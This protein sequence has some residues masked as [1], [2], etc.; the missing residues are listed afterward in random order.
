MAST[1][2]T[3]QD[4]EELVAAVKS[5]TQD[6]T[7]KH[8]QNEAWARS[9]MPVENDLG[10]DLRMFATANLKEPSLF[11]FSLVV[12]RAFRIRGLCVNRGH[13][14]KHTDRN[15]WRPGTH[16]HRW[17]DKCRDRFAYTPTIEISTNIPAAFDEFC[18][19]CNIEFT[20]QVRPLPSRQMD[21]SEAAQA[22]S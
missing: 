3:E 22:Q 4:A 5:I 15:E 17:T 14:N 20:G 6:L 16:A 18:Q 8:S 2:L 9:E 11:T 1:P 19:E 21:I 10:M 13:I 12:S 7:W